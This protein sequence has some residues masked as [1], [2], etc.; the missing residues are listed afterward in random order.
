MIK[1][2]F[3][4]K[5]KGDYQNVILVESIKALNNG[6]I[7]VMFRFTEW[8]DP[9]EGDGILYICPV[10]KDFIEAIGI[11]LSDNPTFE[12][13][14]KLEFALK[15]T[16]W[17][18]YFL[19]LDIVSTEGLDSFL[20]H[21]K[22]EEDHIVQNLQPKDIFKAFWDRSEDKPKPT[23]KFKELLDSEEEERK[24]KELLDNEVEDLPF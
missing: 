3:I 11:K 16:S 4:L 6:F 13:V 14:S 18:K 17:G 5:E 12:E 1:H 21:Y 8:A 2:N 9:L 15:E 22:K 7:P 24:F 23:G 19:G 20:S 10:K